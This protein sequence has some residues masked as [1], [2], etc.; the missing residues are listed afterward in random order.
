M[1]S[2]ITGDSITWYS[3]LKTRM[4]NMYQR[5]QRPFSS[6][7]SNFTLGIIAQWN[8]SIHGKSF[9]DKNINQNVVYNPNTL[10]AS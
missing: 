8:N 9:M 3:L 10:E 5:P 7:P 1:L 2:Y 4:A 6:S